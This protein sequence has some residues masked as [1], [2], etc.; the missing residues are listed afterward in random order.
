MRGKVT[1]DSFKQREHD[2][3]T[4]IK[5]ELVRAAVTE[6]S[7]TY[8]VELEGPHPARWPASDYS[9][10]ERDNGG[11]WIK[12]IHTETVVRAYAHGAW[13]G[14]YLEVQSATHGVF[15]GGWT[16]WTPASQIRRDE[17]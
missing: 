2:R 6:Q 12:D 16:T 1:S 13:K 8:V 5:E 7:L 9:L 3:I 4:E 15:D 11:L 17:A 14:F 10:H